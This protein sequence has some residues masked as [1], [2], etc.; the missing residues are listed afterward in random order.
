MLLESAAAATA[1]I[2]GRWLAR[3]LEHDRSRLWVDLNVPLG[4]RA[5]V[6]EANRA[7][8]QHDSLNVVRN[9]REHRQQQ[10]DVGQA[11]GGNDGGLA[12]VRLVAYRAVHE[13]QEALAR[14]PQLAIQIDRGP[15]R[16]WS[17]IGRLG[18]LG[19]EPCRAVNLGTHA[20]CAHERPGLAS[21]HWHLLAL[22]R[23][24]Q[25]CVCI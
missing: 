22:M 20:S 1:V 21:H 23:M 24:L 7:A 25:R 3:T 12:A 11:A 10:G 18:W 9:I 8:H 13:Q 4:C 5:R 15:L 19:V 2:G 6:T 14:V 17:F 16:Q